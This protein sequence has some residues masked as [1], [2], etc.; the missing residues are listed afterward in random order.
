MHAR[1]RVVALGS[2]FAAIALANPILAIAQPGGGGGAPGGGAAG[3]G[4]G[5]QRQPAALVWAPKPTQLTEYEAPNRPLWKLTDV[6]AMH[7]GQ[8]SWR[9]PIIRD[10]LLEADYVQMAPGQS[11]PRQFFGD[12]RSWFMVWDGQVRVNINGVEP[13][14]ASKGYMVQVPLMVD[15]SLEVVGNTP[16]LFFDVRVT[17]SPLYYTDVNL[18]PPATPGV[19]W[20]RGSRSA[21]R[22]A[23]LDTAAAVP[24]Y[25]DG[26]R[27]YVDFFKEVVEGAGPF[28]PSAFVDD[29]RGF[30]NVIRGRGAPTPPET[31]LGH[32]HTYGTEFWFI[33]EG[34]IEVLIEGV[35]LVSGGPGDII[36]AAEGR[37]HRAGAAGDGMS[38]RIATNGYPEGLHVYQTPEGQ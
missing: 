20:Y 29:D 33:P 30:F 23:Q 36:T 38:T 18:T 28:R 19:T 37:F 9:Q 8:A 35:G 10:A 11:T 14:V 5:G 25:S 26:R 6:L 21:P 17:G 27:V 3:G 1:M 15:Y 4:G 7:Q 12:T 2:A 24:T 31:N 32:F 16:A 22:A 34:T 13:F